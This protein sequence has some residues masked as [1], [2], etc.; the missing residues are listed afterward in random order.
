MHMNKHSPRLLQIV[1]VAELPKE[2]SAMLEH[3]STAVKSR[4]DSICLLAVMY[5]L[6]NLRIIA[7]CSDYRTSGSASAG[8]TVWATHL[9]GYCDVQEW[10]ISEFIAVYVSGRAVGATIRDARAYLH[11][12][13]TPFFQIRWRTHKLNPRDYCSQCRRQNVF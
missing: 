8:C 1:L 6:D 4:D 3:T 2:R 12:L 9:L 5:T 7:V 13:T 10:T 11:K